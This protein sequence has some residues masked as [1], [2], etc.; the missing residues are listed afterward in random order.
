MKPKICLRKNSAIVSITTILIAG[1][2]IG[3][4]G[5]ATY[6]YIENEKSGNIAPETVIS[7]PK[8][9]STIS[10]DKNEKP[11]EIS[12]SSVKTKLKH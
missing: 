9:M 7:E 6:V 1:I 11:E 3:T 4:A 12:L 2:I 8:K 10:Q 5:T